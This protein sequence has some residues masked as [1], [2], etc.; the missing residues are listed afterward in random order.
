ME[1]SLHL[2]LSSGYLPDEDRV[3]LLG[4]HALVKH[5]DKMRRVLSTY[6]F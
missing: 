4:T 1:T 5:L 6:D 2:L 3:V